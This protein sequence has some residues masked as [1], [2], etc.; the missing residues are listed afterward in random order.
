LIYLQ[1]LC[2]DFVGVVGFVVLKA[3]VD[4]VLEAFW[5][6][7]RVVFLASESTFLFFLS[8]VAFDV[9]DL[10]GVIL[11]G[12][13]HFVLVSSTFSKHSAGSGIS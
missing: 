12:D 13:V 7:L 3:L 5:V 10:E 11:F 6:P 1:I 2:S 9:V 4:V 8:V